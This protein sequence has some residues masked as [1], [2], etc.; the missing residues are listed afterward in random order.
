MKFRLK[1]EYLEKIYLTFIRPVLEYS[2]EVWDNCG[3]LNSERLE[4]LQLEAARIV[5]GLTSYAS[6]QSL[7]LE[8]GWEK[9]KIRREVKKLTLFYK[10]MKEDAPEYLLDLIPPT[11]AE[12]NNYNLRSSQNIY[13]TSSRLSLYQESF[14]PSSIKLWNSLDLSVRNELSLNMFKLKIKQK[15]YKNKSPPTYFNIGDRYLNVLHARLRN[16]CSALNM[17]LYHA[18][19]KPNAMC[20]CGYLYENAQH[21]FL[22]CKNYT[23]QRNKLFFELRKENIPT[24]FEN[25]MY[26]NALFN[27]NIN[28]LI[29]IKVQNYIKETNRFS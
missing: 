3:Q 28:T 25:L 2:S 12:T 15:Y 6:T 11:V 19:I 8:T 5:T 26:G 13:Q 23:V 17:D 4:K 22:S 16:K 1:R 18:N 7:Y 14:I 27:M 29:F 9:L 20:Q 24:D 10:I 21:Y